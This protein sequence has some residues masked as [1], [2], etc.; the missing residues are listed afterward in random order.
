MML[1]R[2]G[3]LCAL[4]L[5]AAPAL[6]A[7]PPLKINREITSEREL[8]LE[9]GQNRLMETSEPLGR[10]SV[11]NPEVADL[12]VV[13]NS[14]L[15]VTAKG[16]GDTYLTLWDK[17]DRPLVMSLHVTR[18]LD[19]L[20]KQIKDLFPDEQINVSAAGDLVVLAGEVSDLRVPERVAQVARLHSSKLANLLRVRGNQQVQLEVKF[21]EV[22]RTGLREMGFGWFHQ[23]LDA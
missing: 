3:T 16:V 10:V 13:T 5:S 21:A 19:A 18:N 23:H 2:W 15:L 17:S 4:L 11:A 7:D 14:Q 9:V 22:S 6:A 1:A 8:S 12:K 20:R